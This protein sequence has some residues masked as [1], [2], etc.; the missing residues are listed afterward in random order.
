[1]SKDG[2]YSVMD[3]KPKRKWSDA[4]TDAYLRRYGRVYDAAANA[5][6]LLDRE[7]EKMRKL[8]FAE[9]VRRGRE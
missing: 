5:A 7:Q 6:A 1:M 3:V 2:W 4:T 9:S 8:R